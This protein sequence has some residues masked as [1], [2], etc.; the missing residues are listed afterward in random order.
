MGGTDTGG[1]TIALKAPL[2]AAFLSMGINDTVL[3]DN[4]GAGF[5]VTV[6]MI[7]VYDFT[8]DQTFV[9]WYPIGL[10]SANFIP[11]TLKSIVYLAPSFL[12]NWDFSPNGLQKGYGGQIFP[13]GAFASGGGQVFPY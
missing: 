2:G 9:P 5:G 1:S 8:G 10:A 12:P 11:D 6:S 13:S 4:G 7:E 3:S